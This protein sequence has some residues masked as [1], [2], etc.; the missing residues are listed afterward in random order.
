LSADI[1]SQRGGSELLFGSPIWDGHNRI[2]LSDSDIPC[3]AD[4]VVIGGGFTGLS[5]AFELA[6]NGR[7]VVLLESSYVGYGASARNAGFCTIGPSASASSVLDTYGINEGKQYFH[8]FLKAVEKIEALIINEALDVDWTVSGR[9][10]LARSARQSERLK[11]NFQIQREHFKFPGEFI[12]GDELQEHICARGFV[13][14][15]SDNVSACL[16]PLKLVDELLR[17]AKREGASIH[18]NTPVIKLKESSF[19]VEVHHKHGVLRARQVVIATNGYT[20]PMGI[21]A[22]NFTIPLGSFIVATDPL[23]LE[24]QKLLLPTGKVSSTISNFS[25]YFR[26]LKDG[27]LLFGGRKSLTSNGDLDVISKELRLA[28]HELF[29]DVIDIPE[30]AKCWGGRL[31]FTRD[32]TPLV[33][34]VTERILFAGGYCGHGVPTSVSAGFTLARYIQNGQYQDCPF[35]SHSIRASTVNWMGGKLAPLISMYYRRQD[36]LEL[37]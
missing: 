30:I 36:Y 6:K 28:A 37:N 31:A 5:V 19:D 26:L 15:I 20:E 11:R 9:L 16:N 21:S 14:A 25:N 7:N 23:S 18:E 32:R 17:I 33:G 35:F 29:G 10:S 27:T 8:W 2:T 3:D 12:E 4:I 13:S 24:A 1:K 34:K 22:N